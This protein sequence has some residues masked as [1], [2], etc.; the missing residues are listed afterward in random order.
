MNYRA[1][2]IVPKPVPEMGLG[3]PL[4]CPIGSLNTE[5]MFL[6]SRTF[7]SPEVDVL[8][9]AQGR[10]GHAEDALAKTY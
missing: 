10:Y 2:A 4:L 5:L 9:R 3:T 1:L 7:P 8:A 6:Q